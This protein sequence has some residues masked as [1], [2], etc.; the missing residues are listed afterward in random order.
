MPASLLPDVHIPAVSVY[1]SVFGGLSDEDLGSVAIIDG[2]SGAETTFGELLAH[3]NAIA[4]ALAARGVVLG[5]VI[6]LLC[7][8]IPA[9]ASVFHGILRSGATVTT[10]NSL[11]TAE[12]IGAQLRDSGASWIFTVSPLL[13]GAA[14][15]AAEAGI[16]AERIVVLDGAEGHPSLRDLL[17]AGE[18]APVISFD[19]ATHIAVLPYSSGTTGRPKGVMLTHTNLVANVAQGIGA[20][21]V[22]KGERVLAVLP[23]FHIY[24]LTV[25]LNYA[26]TLRAVL[27]TMPRFDLVE[28]LRITSEHRCNWLFIAP[29]IAVALAKHPVVNAYDLSSVKVVFSGAAPLNGAL[30][31]AVATRLGCIV[32]QG[33]GM[34]EASPAT[35]VIPLARP[36]IDRSSV[37]FALPNTESRVIDPETGL[38]V[39]VPD[40][41][42]SEPG[43]LL[44]RGPQVMAGYLG[45]PD[46]TAA[47]VDADG[48]LHTGDL[49]TVDAEGIYRIVDRLK[50]LIKYKG[51]QVAPAVLEAILLQ[52]SGIADAAVVGA[53]DEDGQEIPKAFVVLQPGAALSA[54]EV[55]AFVAGR[56]AP[57]E[58]VRVVEFID[59]IPKSS[60]GKIL[61]RELRGR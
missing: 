22:E 32:A 45:K 16:P 42:Q 26:L 29:P 27:V 2:A 9:F 53:D 15:A 60:A 41:G 5:D 57:H 18:P 30:A 33:Y 23:F 61:R 50:E 52:H 28:F 4:G 46:E 39:V 31:E 7:P 56:V 13:A 14:A 37:G 21:G 11:Y 6:G 43:E 34:T 17:T 24:G 54:D 8:N 12:E 40:A 1:E 48:W 44:V 49:A 10:I 38:D 59:A 19:P 51:Y 36:D 25:L 47:T 3:V 20:I 35:H 55:I 58:K